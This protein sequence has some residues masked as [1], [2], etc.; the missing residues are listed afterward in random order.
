MK[1]QYAQMKKKTTWREENSVPPRRAEG[2]WMGLAAPR[3][4]ATLSRGETYMGR[5]SRLMK[6]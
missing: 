1:S 4:K 2:P 6:F 3:Y 5:P